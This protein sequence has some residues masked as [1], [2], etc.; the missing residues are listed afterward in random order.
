MK[1]TFFA[2]KV[3]KETK[4]FFKQ[5]D[6]KFPEFHKKVKIA[7]P[8]NPHITIKFLGDTDEKLI[9]KIDSALRE[10]MGKL[11]SFSFFCEGTGC[12]PKDDSPS[13]LWLGIN[14]GLKN[15]QRIHTLLE[16]HLENSG[17]EKDKRKF[18]PHLTLGRVKRFVKNIDSI[19]EFLKYEFEP[20]ENSV[21]ELIWFESKLTSNGAIHK[22]L[23]IYKLK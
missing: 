7:N 10:E 19:D 13:V 16:H 22:P 9:D 20:I 6:Q 3:S 14:K 2:I 5:I 17:I 1:R 23:R 18:T 15:I 4:K 11:D 21:E 8:N 12:F